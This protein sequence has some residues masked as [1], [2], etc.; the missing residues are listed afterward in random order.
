M[1]KKKVEETENEIAETSELTETVDT[2]QAPE[3][4]EEPNNEENIEIVF[5]TN[6]KHGDTRYKKGESLE[7]SE[8]E[9]EILLK[10][11]VID[12]E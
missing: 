6:V 8:E 10:A 9:Y 2:S 11:G 1:A 4:P 12:N 5:N 7:V 3:T